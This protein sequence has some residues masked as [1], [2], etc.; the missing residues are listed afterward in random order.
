MEEVFMFVKWLFLLATVVPLN[1]HLSIKSSICKEN[2]QRGG[3]EIEISATQI[4]PVFKRDESKQCTEER[5]IELKTM[6]QDLTSTGIKVFKSIKGQLLT[7]RV[8]AMCG[9]LT[10]NINIFYIPLEKKEKAIE[11]GFYSCAPQL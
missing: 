11:R 3:V 8:I 2:A 1:P 7:G 6:K 4:I 9:A 5:G 10:S